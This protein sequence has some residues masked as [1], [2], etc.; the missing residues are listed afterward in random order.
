MDYQRVG[1]LISEL[2]KE[3][4][5]TQRELSEKLG[6]TD[7]AVSKWER[8]LGCPDVSL[9]DD[10]SR[11]LDISIIEILKGRRLDKDEIANNKNMI[12]SM[13]YSKETYKNRIKRNINIVVILI[14]S[15]I[16][17]SLLLQNLNAFYY[18]NIKTYY[19][20][21]SNDD[22]NNIFDEFE[23]NIKLIKNNQGKYSNKDYQI[24]LDYVNKTDKKLNQK[25]DKFYLN[26]KKY[27]CNELLKFI[28]KK[29]G[30]IDFY[31][32]NEHGKLIYKILIKYNTNLIDSL[33]IYYS[34]ENHESNARASL[35]EET[36]NIL[37]GHSIN[38][39][40]FPNIESIIYLKY[41][42]I[43]MILNKIIETGDINE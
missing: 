21:Y 2:R 26:K 3:K 14:I 15:I 25:E 27:K 28:N 9:L 23:K 32:Q 43:N 19:N 40:N 29:M 11:I 37:K 20:I 31:T 33:G 1:N 8:G 10:L 34:F 42:R 41:E 13:T 22:E 12:E 7:R 16:C 38:I 36:T 4:G 39:E 18:G 24:I 6:I 30:N 17:F 5:M 35:M